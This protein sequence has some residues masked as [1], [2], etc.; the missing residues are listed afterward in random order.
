MWLINGPPLS[1][2]FS[3]LRKEGEGETREGRERKEGVRMEGEG[4]REEREGGT[5]S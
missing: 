4:R 3:K 2:T 1:P 5:A